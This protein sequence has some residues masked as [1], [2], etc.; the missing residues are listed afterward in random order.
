LN[1]NTSVNKVLDI[2]TIYQ[3][4]ERV[5]LAMD[6]NFKDGLSTGQIEKAI[7]EIEQSIKSAFPYIER[8]YVEAEERQTDSKTT[9]A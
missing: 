3:S 5:L 4:P 1:K 7:D 9:N 6:L 8:I 2:K